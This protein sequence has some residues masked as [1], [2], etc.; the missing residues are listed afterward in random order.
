MYRDGGLRAKTLRVGDEVARRP[1]IRRR[2]Q[3]Q[4]G[5]RDERGSDEEFVGY[6]SDEGVELQR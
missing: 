3:Q 6:E 4:R 5:D 1:K 2:Q